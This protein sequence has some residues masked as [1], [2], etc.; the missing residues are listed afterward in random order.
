MKMKSKRNVVLDWLLWAILIYL[1]SLAVMYLAQ[2]N[3]MYLPDKHMPM[4]I[5][6]G[7]PAMHIVSV[8][9]EDGLTLSGWFQPPEGNKPVILLFHGN[10]GHQ[11]IR[12]FKALPYMA[13]G[14]GFL[15]G[16]YRGYGGNPGKPTEQGL[17]QDGD[18][19]V[20]WLVE[21]QHY[22]PQQIVLYGESLGTGVVLQTAL[23]YPDLKALIL[24]SPFTSF[25]DLARKHYFWVPAIG[26]LVKDH[27]DNREK[28]PD[29]HIPVLIVHGKR[30]T[31][32]PYSQGRAIYELANEPKAMV[33]FS[34]A[35]HNDLYVFGA[36]QS[37][38]DYLAKLD[39]V[40]N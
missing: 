22:K 11:G 4:P 21:V 33:T 18:A 28:I 31:V 14:Y 6:S 3:M 34:L 19:W 36:A 40:D 16:T 2:R 27:Y 7:L 26:S 20:K 10:A 13:A 23:A 24:E 39:P 32:V 5:Q 12:A 1:S 15:F 8:H 35:N 25:V 9:T 30:D 17:Y 29:I 37:I 38:L